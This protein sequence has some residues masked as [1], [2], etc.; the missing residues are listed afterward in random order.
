MQC[1]HVDNTT[2]SDKANY[3]H[4]IM[5]QTGSMKPDAV[6]CPMI[7]VF[8][9]RMAILF[10][11]DSDD[12]IVYECPIVSNTNLTTSNYE[13]G[14]CPILLTLPLVYFDLIR[15]SWL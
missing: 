6:S 9:I 12:P 3:S 7:K 1:A 13:V 5:R 14:N 4:Q 10:V 11:D 2:H 15:R 8:Q